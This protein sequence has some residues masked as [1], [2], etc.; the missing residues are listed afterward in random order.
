MRKT[1]IMLCLAVMISLS[2]C[3]GNINGGVNLQQ[4]KDNT[5]ENVMRISIQEIENEYHKALEG[6]ETFTVDEFIAV[7]VKLFNEIK[8]ENIDDSD[9]DND[10][11][12]FQ[13]GVYD[14]SDENG[15]HF[16]FDITRQIRVPDEDEPY[17]L[18]L[19]LLFDPSLFYEI[20]PY[21]CWSTEYDNTEKFA[22]HIKT[23]PGY[24]AVSKNTAKKYQI[25]FGQC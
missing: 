1:I 10:M 14:W 13:Y 12:L 9:A 20:K 5:T 25:S 6:I 2:A 11:L 23:T 22:D 24:E 15:K 18:N 3:D 21:N 17:Q 19:S 16:E 7:A 4:N 8:I